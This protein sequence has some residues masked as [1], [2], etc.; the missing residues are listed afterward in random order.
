MLKLVLLSLFATFSI[1]TFAITEINLDG[2]DD[3]LKFNADE[4]IYKQVESYETYETTCYEEVPNGTRTECGTVYETHCKKVP[5][6]CHQVPIEMCSEVQDTRT[7]SY[8][9]TGTRR[10]I[11]NE[12]DYSVHAAIEVV[13][14]PTARDFDLNGCKLG[15]MLSGNGESFSVNC[16]SAIVRAK[17][18]ERTEASQ[19]NDKARNI[20]VALD[21]SSIVDLN[22]LK[23]GLNDLKFLKGILTFNAGNL[24]TAKNFSLS[25]KLKRNRFILKDVMLF[26]RE[27]KSTDFTVKE[28][29]SQNF[30][31]SVDIKKLAPGFDSSRKNTVTLNLRAI[32]PVDLSGSINQ[33]SLSNE[34]NQSLVIKERK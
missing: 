29:A 30:L 19:G 6:E 20:K 17:V 11:I 18:L 26:D 12:Y 31:I 27:L 24:E 1:Q 8:P 15:V 13:K 4:I 22:A 33:P 21:F 25:M 10:V 28:L 16:N 34:L 14:T 23:H 2:K 9:C 32:K 3:T 5:Y 7:E